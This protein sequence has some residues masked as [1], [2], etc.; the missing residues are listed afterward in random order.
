MNAD[1]S[2][3]S[4]RQSTYSITSPL[5]NLAA[6]GQFHLFHMLYEQMHIAGSG[7]DL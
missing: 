7:A 6:I 1:F 4:F 5:T 2:L 3:V